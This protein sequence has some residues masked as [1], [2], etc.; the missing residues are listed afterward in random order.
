MKFFS[1]SS[2]WLR[3]TSGLLAACM[4]TAAAP[5]QTIAELASDDMGPFTTLY[6]LVGQAGLASA[7]SDPAAEL[8]VLAPTDEAFGKL[9]ADVVSY[10]TNPDNVA[11]LVSVLE[12]HV[13]PGKTL[14]ADIPRGRSG[15]SVSTLLTDA[16]VNLRRFY[17]WSWSHFRWFVSVSVNKGEAYVIDADIEAVNGVI[18]AIDTV[19]IP[20]GFTLPQDLVDLAASAGLSTLVTAVQVAGL[21]DTLRGGEFTVFAPTNEAFAALPEGLLDYLLRNPETLATVLTHHV[22]AGVTAEASVIVSGALTS[23]TTVQGEDIALEFDGTSVLVNANESDEATVIAADNFASNGVAHVIDAILIPQA[24][25][26]VLPIPTITDAVVDSADL[27]TLETAVVAA[28]LAGVLDGPGPFTVFAPIDAAFT[29]LGS[30][31]TDLLADPMGDLKDILEFHV[32]SGYFTAEDITK[33]HLP[34]GLKT[35]NGAAIIAKKDDSGALVLDDRSGTLTNIITADQA[36]FNGVVHI[37]DKVLLPPSCPYRSRWLC[38]LAGY[39]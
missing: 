31:L 29:P 32:V 8:T 2:A 27:T 26:D 10:L 13:I 36:F 6:A 22:V 18:H 4:A 7:L 30:T 19:L 34:V 1:L 21:E 33:Y 14:A 5:T 15:V 11:D 38:W 35:V 3:V 23:A 12:Y 37:I 28:G 20:P 9:D 24:I 25:V 39:K 17:Y 16:M